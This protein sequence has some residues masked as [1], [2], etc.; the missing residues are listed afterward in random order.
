MLLGEP[1]NY[2]SGG[3]FNRRKPEYAISPKRGNRLIPGIFPRNS[4]NE[5]KSRES[6]KKRMFR[7]NSRTPWDWSNLKKTLVVLFV[8]V[9]YFG[10]IQ[11]RVRST[12]HGVQ[13][14]L[15]SPAGGISLQMIIVY[16]VM[17]LVRCGY[18]YECALSSAWLS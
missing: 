1:Q 13:K 16:R 12:R 10:Y 18:I 11:S 8:S 14:I 9:Q 7:E 15:L 5:E 6:K 4:T 2:I 3:E 17:L